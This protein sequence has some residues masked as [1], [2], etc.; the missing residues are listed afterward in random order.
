MILLL[1]GMLQTPF[2]AVLLICSMLLFGWQYLNRTAQSTIII[3]AQPITAPIPSTFHVHQIRRFLIRENTTRDD[4]VEDS[5]LLQIYMEVRGQEKLILVYQDYYAH[6][7]NEQ[8]QAIF[9]RLSN[10]LDRRS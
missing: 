5:H 2:G 7:R 8:T 6:K 4:P 1:L 3:E 10:W 9:E